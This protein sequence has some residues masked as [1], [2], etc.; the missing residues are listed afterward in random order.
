FSSTAPDKVGA[1][2]EAVR[3][4]FDQF[5]AEGPTDDEMDVAKRQFETVLEEQL[6]EP[7]TWQRHLA[8]AEY[9]GRAVNQPLGAL[10][11]YRSFSANEVREAFARYYKPETTFRA[12]VKPLK[13]AP[14]AA[15][16]EDDHAGGG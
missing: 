5:A 10:A 16:A 14:E 7:S 4:M 13:P 3:A 15:A 11:A 8:T 12:Y 2:L 9:R 1:L 6:R